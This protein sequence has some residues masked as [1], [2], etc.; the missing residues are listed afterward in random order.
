[1]L[2]YVAA[3]VK[4]DELTMPKR[5]WRDAPAGRA[6]DYTFV[7][8]SDEDLWTIRNRMVFYWNSLT[9]AA[10]GTAGAALLLMLVP[11]APAGDGSTPGGSGM[12]VTVIAGLAVA[13]VYMAVMLSIARKRCG[14]LLPPSAPSRGSAR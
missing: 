3:L 1:V 11:G 12:F 8:L 13:V 10:T 6:D 4:L 5:F 14:V 9:L 2:L 7:L